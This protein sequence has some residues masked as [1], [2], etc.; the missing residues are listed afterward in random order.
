MRTLL[1]NAIVL[2]ISL[3]VAL[4]LSELALWLFGFDYAPFYRPDPI[5]GLGLRPNASGWQHR[6]GRA[7]ISINSAGMRDRDRPVRKPAGTYRI[8]VL[9]DSYTEGFQVD[10]EATFWRLLEK[11]LQ[12]CGFQ[13]GKTIDVLNFGVSGEGTGQELLVL[14]TRAMRYEPDLV[15]VAF[16]QGNDVRNNS[17]ELEEDK[18]RPFY[19]LSDSGELELDASFVQSAEFQRR[20][21]WARQFAQEVSQHLR[22]LQLV[23]YVK[24][25]RQAAPTRA[26]SAPS[27][28]GLDDEVFVPPRDG[29]AW[30]RA[31]SLTERLVVRAKQVAADGGADF[32]LTTLSVGIQVSPDKDKRE[33]FAAKLGV[34]DLF[35]PERRLRELGASAGIH[36]VTLAPELQAYADEH[37]VYL[38]G[39]KNTAMGSGHWNEA[40]HAQGAEILAR[41]LCQSPSH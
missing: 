28:L 35:Y 34:P 19:F 15:L 24:D 7:Y 5:T 11:R 41:N 16:F 30:A 20:N 18:V 33:A 21:G 38:H 6:E 13:Q 23:Y 14:E 37:K 9:G 12:T 26:G 39:F 27:E 4:I 1:L 32:L 22:T 25:A 8:A 3:A 10:V 31:W 36:V 17:R 29:T 2:I 40:G